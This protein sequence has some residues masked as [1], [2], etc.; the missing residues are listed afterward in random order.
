MYQEIEQL[1]DDQLVARDN[2][3]KMS[4]N[5]K[6][7]IDRENFIKQHNQVICIYSIVG[8]KCFPVAD[9]IDNNSAWK[10][11]LK[12]SNSKKEWNFCLS[13][14]PSRELSFQEI[15]MIKT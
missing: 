11:F 2:W 1:T 4:L 15:Q 13:N 6:Q 9:F 5:E 8:D 3:L 14:R 7:L 12:T 10:Y